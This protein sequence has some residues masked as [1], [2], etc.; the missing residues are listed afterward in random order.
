[1]KQISALAPEIILLFRLDS[2]TLQTVKW[3]DFVASA[4][5]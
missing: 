2:N 3:S 4:R 5:S 1:M